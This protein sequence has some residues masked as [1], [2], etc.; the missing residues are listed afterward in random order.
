MPKHLAKIMRLF[1]KLRVTYKIKYH[2]L[3]KITQH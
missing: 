3:Q 1:A 2:A